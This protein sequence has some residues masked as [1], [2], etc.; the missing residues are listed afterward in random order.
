[1]GSET[2]PFAKPL[3]KSDRWVKFGKKWARAGFFKNITHPKN[4]TVHHTS[5]KHTKLIKRQSSD[6]PSSDATTGTTAAYKTN[7]KLT[8][9]IHKTVSKLKCSINS[10]ITE[11]ESLSHGLHLDKKFLV[12][13]LVQNLQRK[14]LAGVLSMCNELSHE[15][16]T[17]HFIQFYGIAKS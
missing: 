9:R 15:S 16:Q 17:A 14:I 12:Q 2:L 11:N 8:N 3:G 1:M 4:H 10:S 5:T 7:F 13:K 6:F